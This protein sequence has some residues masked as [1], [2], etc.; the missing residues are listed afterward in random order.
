M[1][2]D[3]VASS[4]F[5]GGAR[6]TATGYN[7]T[8]GGGG[9]TSSRGAASPRRAV[10]AAAPPL[11]QRAGAAAPPPSAASG[12]AR[13]TMPCARLRKKK[14]LDSLPGDRRWWCWGFLGVAIDE[15][16][17]RPGFILT[18]RRTVRRPVTCLGTCV[19]SGELL[20]KKRVM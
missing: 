15:V 11:A 10:A 7:A 19:R 2:T 9:F 4:A 17:G 18:R 8:S 20:A 16:L 13:L 3:Q 1:F 12:M 5:S 14:L 6:T